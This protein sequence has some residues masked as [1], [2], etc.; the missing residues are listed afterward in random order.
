[1]TGVNAVIQ[2]RMGSTRL[3]GKVLRTLGDRTVLAHVIGRVQAAKQVDRIVVATTTKA[4]DDPI[5]AE[6]GRLGVLTTRGPDRNVLGR[7]VMA[8]DEHGGDTGVRL[9]ADCPFL[10]PAIVDA[11][12]RQFVAL[13]PLDYLSN[14]VV[15]SFPRGLDVEVFRVEALH[16][17]DAQASEPVDREHVTPFLYRHPERFRVAHY[18]RPDPRRSGKWR[19]TLDTLEDWELLTAVW[20]A[21]RTENPLFGVS[22]IE[23][24]LRDRPELLL[25]NEDVQQRVLGPQYP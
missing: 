2:A 25:I 3:P 9:T 5:V 22:A 24:L 14:T 6:A 20:K 12:V 17:A 4:E 1:M 8:F 13:Q 19:L 11:V 10:D 23:R 15:R 21:L 7:Y 16:I 18:T